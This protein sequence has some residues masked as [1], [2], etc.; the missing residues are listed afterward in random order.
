MIDTGGE[1]ESPICTQTDREGTE[2]ITIEHGRHLK[3]ERRTQAYRVQLR[4]TGK[5]EFIKTKLNMMKT[6]ALART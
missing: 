3:A 2:S 1:L 4:W 6:L 5:C